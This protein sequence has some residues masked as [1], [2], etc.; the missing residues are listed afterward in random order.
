[1]RG[2]LVITH[3]RGL[4]ALATGASPV[5]NVKMLRMSFGSRSSVAMQTW[6]EKRKKKGGS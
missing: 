4:V 1:V 3:R 6:E 5:S 2:N